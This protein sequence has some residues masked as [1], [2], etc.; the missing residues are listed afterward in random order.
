MELIYTQTQIDNAIS[1]LLCCFGNEAYKAALSQGY[2]L[3]NSCVDYKA[4]KKFLI[5]YGLTFWQQDANGD[6]SSYTNYWTQEQLTN[7][8]S[9][10]NEN[11]KC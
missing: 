8:I 4:M 11:C 9:W 2:G 10:I 7:I 1:K 3:D 6:T 5:L